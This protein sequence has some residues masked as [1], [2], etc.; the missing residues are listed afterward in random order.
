MT[1]ADE[2][3]ND[4]AFRDGKIKLRFIRAKKKPPGSMKNRKDGEIYWMFPRHAA[5]P[6]WDVVDKIDYPFIPKA[7]LEES[8]LDLG[9]L[10]DMEKPAYLGPSGFSV[11]PDGLKGEFIEP[12]A[13]EE[14]VEESFYEP[15]PTEKWTKKELLAFI[16]SKGGV[17][18]M[19]MRKA[20]LL[21]IA[22]NL[23]ESKSSS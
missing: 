11:G 8:V 5:F 7:S 19:A 18:K 12:I 10:D 20:W 14:V 16:T 22:L 6:W 9:R 1:E 2:Q 3:T 13:S 17:A 15:P 21:E 4:A 23:A